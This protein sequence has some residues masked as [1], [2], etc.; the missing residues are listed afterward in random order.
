MP[1]VT[2][3][4]A[5]ARYAELSLPDTTQ[6]AWRFTS[7]KGFDPDSYGSNGHVP[8][9][10]PGTMLDIDV[11]GLAHV[12]EDGIEIES[13]PEGVTVQPL[14]EDARLGTFVCADDKFTAHNAASWKHGLL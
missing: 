13:A 2:R 12:T 4:E 11:A 14:S 7:L 10:V 8:G 5:A 1:R 9:T 6:E 3:A